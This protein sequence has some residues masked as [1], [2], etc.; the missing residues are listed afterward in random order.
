MCCTVSRPKCPAWTVASGTSRWSISGPRWTGA[1]C[2]KMNTRGRKLIR[3]ITL[4]CPFNVSDPEEK[5]WGS[6]Q[7]SWGEKDRDLFHCVSPRRSAAR[8]TANCES[9]YGMWRIKMLWGHG[10]N[11]VVFWSFVWGLIDCFPSERISKNNRPFSAKYTLKSKLWE[12]L[13]SCVFAVFFP[14]FQL[15]EASLGDSVDATVWHVLKRKV[16]K[17]NSNLPTDTRGPDRNARKKS[18]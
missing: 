12:N 15:L 1:C 10:E 5:I 7:L 18:I 8:G 11:G 14:L 6:R 17:L 9:Y 13:T 16:R 4:L 3:P 2:V